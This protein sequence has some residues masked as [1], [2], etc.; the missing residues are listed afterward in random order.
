MKHKPKWLQ[1]QIADIY[2]DITI[3]G[4]EHRRPATM[5][6]IR[7]AVTEVVAAMLGRAHSL[8]AL[9]PAPADLGVAHAQPGGLV[10][11]KAR[12]Q[13]KRVAMVAELAPP[14]GIEAADDDEVETSETTY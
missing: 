14:V 13:R 4:S 9:E 2:S 11:A 6:G 10:V 3:A 7:R 12:P 8:P 5:P 1:L